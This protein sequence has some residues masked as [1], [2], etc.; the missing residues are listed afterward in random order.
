[1]QVGADPAVL[2]VAEFGRDRVL[3]LRGV[4]VEILHVG[5]QQRAADAP[6][7]VALRPVLLGF[8]A[9]D[10][11]AGAGRDDIG[12]N[13]GRLGELGGDE[14][15]QRRVVRGIDDDALLRLRRRPPNPARRQSPPAAITLPKRRIM[16]CSLPPAL[17]V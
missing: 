2:R 5:L 8:D 14:L 16:I 9:L 12:L 15:V 3:V 6:D 1:M 4:G 13:A 10:D 7:D 11:D 17:L